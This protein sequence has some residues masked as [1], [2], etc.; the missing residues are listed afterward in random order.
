MHTRLMPV[1]S[2]I[3]LIIKISTKYGKPTEVIYTTELNIVSPQGA[4]QLYPQTHKYNGGVEE[5]T[6]TLNILE[7]SCI[8][9]F[10]SSLRERVAGMGFCTRGPLTDPNLIFNMLTDFFN[11]QSLCTISLHRYTDRNTV[12]QI[13]NCVV[14]QRSYIP[15]FNCV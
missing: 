5:N 15:S 2:N 7:I 3:E 9:P 4:Q 8:F 13:Y 12:V 6:L 1:P 11:L 10:L 14:H